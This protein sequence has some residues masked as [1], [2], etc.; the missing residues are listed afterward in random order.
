MYVAITA[1]VDSEIRY[2]AFEFLPASV[3]H[4]VTIKCTL[5][6]LLIRLRVLT[7]FLHCVKNDVIECVGRRFGT[8]KNFGVAPPTRV[9]PRVGKLYP[10]AVKTPV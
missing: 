7:Y 4:T 2:R 8:P 10:W 9:M 6:S 3:N 5:S 1:F